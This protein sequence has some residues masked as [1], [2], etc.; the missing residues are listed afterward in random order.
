MWEDVLS[1]S[2]KSPGRGYGVYCGVDVGKS[3]HHACAL[4]PAGNR[5]YD[6][7]L[8]NDETASRWP[9]R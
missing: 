2:D 7:P 6:R 8:P 1:R 9:A 3:E 4:D 5:L